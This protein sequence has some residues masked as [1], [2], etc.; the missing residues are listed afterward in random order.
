MIYRTFIIAAFLVFNYGCSDSDN[1]DGF[2]LSPLDPIAVTHTPAHA[3][4]T[5]WTE[6]FETQVGPWE[7]LVRRSS[8]YDAPVIGNSYALISGSENATVATAPFVLEPGQRYGVTVWARSA[9]ST[10][11]LNGLQVPD[12]EQLPSGIDTEAVAEI[13]LFVGDVLLA[14]KALIVSPTP[15]LGAPETATNDDGANVWVDS[16][17]GFRHAF[18]ENHFYQPIASD[19]VN[20]EWF[21]AGMPFNEFQPDMMAKG[22]AIFPNGT[23]RIYGF[24]SN[25]PFCIGTGENC[26]AMIF[27]DVL[28]SGAPEYD[29]PAMA[30]ENYIAW[31]SGDEDPWLGDPHI[32]ADTKTGK[33]WLSFGGGTGMYVAELNPETGYILGFDDALS[34]DEHPEVFN[35]VANWSGDEW[36]PDSTWFEGAAL[37]R[38]GDEWYLFTS[39]GNLGTNYTIRVGRGA[40][41]RGPF[42][43][44]QGRDMNALDAGDQEFGNSFVL[45]D[46]SSQL[47]PGH[48]HLWQEGERFFLGYDY[49]YEKRQTGADETDY[50]GIR[51]LHWV[52]GWPTIWKPLRLEFSADDFPQRLGQPIRV[53]LSSLGGADSIVAFDNLT[54]TTKPVIC[55]EDLGGN[56]TPTSCAPPTAPQITNTD[57]GDSKAYISV[58]VTDEDGLPITSYNAI[59][60]DGSVDYTGTS[61]TSPILVSGLTNGVSYTC[62]VTATN[63]AGTSTTS[64]YV[65]TVSYDAR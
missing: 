28:G 25:N 52:D 24:N 9:Y 36:T 64:E 40:S 53:A 55:P 54:V 16:A 37:W 48:P 18:A 23:K 21:Q 49:R 26:Q 5:L 2:D 56:T 8:E 27:A 44:K 41:P 43:D 3:Q 17:A 4:Q 57:Y 30:S 34:F 58:S 61:P 42:V 7:D 15:I 51:E 50:F 60:T 33:V 31:H 29:V 39:N 11:H 59:C 20:D 63:A 46:D 22:V 38:Q 14:E 45:G 35:Q 47:V 62:S 12:L 19:P 6:S 1:D 32:F 13:G 10:E 65:T